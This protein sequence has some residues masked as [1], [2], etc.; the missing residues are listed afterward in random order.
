MWISR[1]AYQ[2][3]QD[4][5]TKHRAE[6]VAQNRANQMLEATM[7]WLRHRVTQI[8]AE[9][10]VLIDKFMGVKIPAPEF[11]APKVRDPFAEHPFNEMD[12]FRGL[13]DAEALKEGV[14]WDEDGKLKQK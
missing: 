12:I 8:E 7:N 5:L 3:L 2:D 10:A 14:E 1:Q 9:R 11:H 13:S 4:E 6:L